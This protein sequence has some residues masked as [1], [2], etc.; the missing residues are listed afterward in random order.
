LAKGGRGDLEFSY[1]GDLQFS[2]KIE[3]NSFKFHA[4]CRHTHHVIDLVLDLAARN[5]IS[6]DEVARLVVGTY[7]TALDIA[8]NPE[9]QSAFAAKFSLP[10]CAALA[11]VKGSC[12]LE[13]FL[14]DSLCDSEIR[15]LAGR[16]HLE[17]DDESE[18]L[19][20]VKWGAR[21]EVVTVTG[22][23]Y[24]ARAD[25]PRGDP[26]NPLDDQELIAKFCRLAGYSRSEEKVETLLQAAL[27]LEDLQDIANLFP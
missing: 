23:S 15:R 24:S 10:F 27:H 17:I 21:V 13:D 3:E 9:P 14:E 16:V 6:P 26:E 19:H 22:K 20:P 5:S 4:S 8:G 18:S 2:Y 1:K 11:L 7:R 25:F 12:G